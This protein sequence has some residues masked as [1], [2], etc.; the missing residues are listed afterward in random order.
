MPIWA[1]DIEIV[2]V[3][4]M[5]AKDGSGREVPVTVI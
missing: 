5:R 2:G 4:I 3:P 1:S